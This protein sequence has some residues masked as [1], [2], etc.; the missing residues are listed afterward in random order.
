MATTQKDNVV[1]F[2]AP[3]ETRVRL[4]IDEFLT[5]NDMTNLL[6]LALSEVQMEPSK[7][8]LQKRGLTEDWWTFYSLSSELL[9]TSKRLTFAY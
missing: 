4:E 8:E 9:L 6:I 5:D 2:I 3:S 7:A 1:Q